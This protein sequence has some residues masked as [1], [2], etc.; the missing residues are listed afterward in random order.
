M[1]ILV[2]DDDQVSL[3]MMRRMLQGSGYDVV[4]ASDGI[5]AVES[6]LAEGGPRLLLLDW[7][8]PE[9]SGP[10]VCQAIRTQA[11]KG[12]V[13]IILLTARD[14]KDDL[15]AGLEAGADDY[16]T[17]PCNPEELRARLRTGQRVLR[18][19]DD[20]VKAHDE[21]RFR[22]NHDAL[23]SLLNRGAI[24]DTLSADLR[25]HKDTGTNLSVV[26]CDVDHFK[27]INDTY[28]H[29]VGDEVLREVARRLRGVC[30]PGE[31]VGRYGGEEFLLVLNGCEADALPGRAHE[32]CQVIRDTRVQTDSG[33]LEVSI[34]AGALSVRAADRASEPDEVLQRTDV[35]LY[36]AKREGRNRVVSDIRTP[37]L[38]VGPE[39][40]S[41]VYRRQ[42]MLHH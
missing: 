18:L 5:T 6:I 39:L 22:A 21:M 34:S 2:A 40:F 23:T 4:T 37:P 7:M 42:P 41:P 36:R 31:A 28:G 35:L 32:I 8:M 25:N 14:S 29:P 20:L 19:E 24:V 17:K 11:D 10:E 15:I 1:K 16:L 13:Y 30:R 12:Y 9:L 27:R 33:P 38:T 3:M 26:L